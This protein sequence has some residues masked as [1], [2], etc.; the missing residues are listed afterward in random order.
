[1]SLR[2]RLL[3]AFS[4][5]LLFGFF[6]VARWIQGELRNSYAQIVEELLVDYSHVMSSFLERN[7]L[8]EQSLN[9]LGSMFS[10]YRRHRIQ[11]KIF[12]FTKSEPT[13]EI[14]VTDHSGK[15]IYSTK[16]E[17]L[18]RDFSRWNDVYRTL[19][20]EYGAR[21]TRTIPA[22]PR[23]SV[24]YVA[25]PIQ[26][27]G[28][29]AGVVTVYKTESSIL[30]FLDAALNKFVWAGLFFT[31]A[32]LAI[33][34][35]VLMW[36]TYPLSQ[37]Q[38]YALDISDGKK[39]VLPRSNIRE[40]KDLSQAF[41]KMRMSL[42]G[43]KTIEK[44]TQALTHELK[45]PLTAI[46]GAAEL[47]L[48]EMDQVQRRV[49]LKNIIEEANRA[50][51]VL[52]QLLKVAALEAKTGLDDV[53]SVDLI[54]IVEEARSSLLGMWKP[55]N[56]TVKI[57]F[58]TPV[59]I[60][61]DRFLLFQAVRNILQNAIEFSPE[62]SEILVSVRSSSQVATLGVVD[63][64]TGIPEYARSRVFEKFYSLERPDTR[65]KSS[66]L[67]LT[68]VKEVV[69]LHQG[70]IFIHS[71]CVDSHGTEVLLNLPFQE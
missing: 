30:P 18:G 29:L 41:E 5:V 31:L 35:L 49:F 54:E 15:V 48:E 21:S 68:F 67:G 66:G 1:M 46:R 53:S 56:I 58:Q 27:N 34:G 69:E 16:S 8:S 39:S 28:Q 7:G 26:I 63:T 61:G 52:E 71:P 57:Q 37:L 12:E 25:A 13:L 36:V 51:S 50:H 23:T 55:K 42:E 59:R 44:F 70:E 10:S 4:L 64:G 32:L 6:T 24:Y 33:A 47:S 11:A 17:E 2:R 3:L 20:G 22:D 9:E 65:K 62:R 60:Q 43:K 45:S 38:T 40:I 19:R 14:Y